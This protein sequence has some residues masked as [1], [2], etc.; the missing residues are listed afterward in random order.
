MS[1]PDAPR[2]GVAQAVLE[3]AVKITASCLVATNGDPKIYDLGLQAVTASDLDPSVFLERVEFEVTRL[4]SGR[5][6]E[7]PG[8]TAVFGVIDVARRRLE[9]QANNPSAI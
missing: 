2:E 8:D 7:K 3:E 4:T 5:T 6:S 9:Y 1:T